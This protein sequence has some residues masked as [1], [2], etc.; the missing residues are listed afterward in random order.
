VGS[1]PW[2]ARTI[3]G[4]PRDLSVDVL[5]ELG[6]VTWAA[7][8]LEDY[9]GDVCSRIDPRDP[10]RTDERLT[11]QRIADAKA[12]LAGW[13]PSPWRDQA[14]A[15]LERARRAVARRNAILHAT[16]VVWLGPGRDEQ[17]PGLGEKAGRDRP[18]FERALTV[19][20]LGELRSVLEDA[21]GGWRELVIALGARTRPTLI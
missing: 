12:V 8:R 17:R 15:W 1:T 3:A 6:R 2:P 13:A 16:P 4:M 18:Y 14:D 11:G 9:V 10:R 20:S 7:I 5:T 19:E 21:A